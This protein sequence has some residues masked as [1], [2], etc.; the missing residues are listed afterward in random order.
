MEDGVPQAPPTAQLDVHILYE[1]PDWLPPLEAALQRQG[2]RV[3]PVL[4]DGGALD[5]ALTPP[6]GIFINRMSPS[7][8]DRGHQGGIAYVT[9][10]LYWLEEYGRPVINGSA[11]FALEVSKVRFLYSSFHIQKSNGHKVH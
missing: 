3:V 4:V 10:L 6:E 2:L 9:E 8:H 7:A 5:L 1:N 11:A